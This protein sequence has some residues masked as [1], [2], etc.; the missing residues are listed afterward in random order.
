MRS[1]CRSVVGSPESL[2]A[3]GSSCHVLLSLPSAPCCV[4]LL[5]V[6]VF[7]CSFACYRA[8]EAEDSSRWHRPSWRTLYLRSNG[9]SRSRF[10]ASPQS[11]LPQWGRLWVAGLRITIPGDGSF[12]STCRLVF[13]HSF[14]SFGSS[15]T[16]RT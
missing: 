16:H 9:G 4:G 5:R 7:C 8:L 15:R 12:S 11:S 13:L 1:C 2:A 10:T 6:S 14:W 3:N